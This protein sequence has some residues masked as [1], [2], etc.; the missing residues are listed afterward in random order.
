MIGVDYMCRVIKG[1]EET[2][3]VCETPEGYHENES[4]GC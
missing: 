4:R 3:E 2:R 1:S